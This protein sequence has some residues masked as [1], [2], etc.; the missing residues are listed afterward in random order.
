MS[1]I[2]FLKLLVYSPAGNGKTTILGTALNDDRLMP[3]LIIDFEGGVADAIGSIIQTIELNELK[4]LK[5]TIDKIYHLRVINW[6][7]FQ[8][9]YDILDETMFKT[10]AID[11]LSEINFLNLY[12]VTNKNPQRRPILSQ[13][14]IPKIQD[15]GDSSFQMSVL[16]RAFRD[17]E[18]NFIA[19]AGVSKTTSKLTGEDRLYPNMIG[20]FKEK[21][22]HIFGQVGYLAI[23]PGDENIEAGTRILIVKSREDLEAKFRDESRQ[24]EDMIID[25]TLPKLLDRVNGIYMKEV[26]I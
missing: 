1:L 10:V 23:H 4:I 20:Q 2:A 5:P 13:L 22:A 6:E 16:I 12:T 18:C 21:I 11:S 24:V 14:K 25:P 7:E 8:T 9:I 26:L 3:M 19:T 15:Y 17:L